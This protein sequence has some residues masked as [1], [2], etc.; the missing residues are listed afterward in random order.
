MAV[1]WVFGSRAA[2]TERP[3]SDVDIAILTRPDRPPLDL[4]KLSRLGNRLAALLPGEPDVVAFE[5]APLP[6]QARIVLEGIVLF[7]DDEP[8]RVST[9]VLTQSRWEDV[10]GPLDEMDRA[11]IAGI[12][13][14]GLQGA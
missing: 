10:R 5:R 13:A 14:H 12:A 3:D 7:S 4:L 11:Y 9:T 2:G 6:L 8:L 1:A